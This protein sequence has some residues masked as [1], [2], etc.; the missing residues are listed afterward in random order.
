MHT[1]IVGWMPL[2][3]SRIP[4]REKVLERARVRL[5]CWSISTASLALA[6]SRGYVNMT[7]TD[8]DKERM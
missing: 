4:P 2:Y 7:D 1:Y 3:N 8:P 5:G 6:K